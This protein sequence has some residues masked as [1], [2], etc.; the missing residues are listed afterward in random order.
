M[1]GLSLICSCPSVTNLARAIFLRA[2]ERLSQ[3]IQFRCKLLQLRTRLSVFAVPLTLRVAESLSQT[4]VFLAK[5]IDLIFV[6]TAIAALGVGEALAKLA[7]FDPQRPELFSQSLQVRVR[8]WP[9]PSS[10]EADNCFVF[11]V[12]PELLRTS[13][14][15]L[16]TEGIL[17]KSSSE[18]GFRTAAGDP[19][20]LLAAMA[21]VVVVVV[22]LADV[23]VVEVVV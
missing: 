9:P 4:V 22:G 14:K 7:I 13:Q 17:A 16:L 23:V 11:L 12:A 15:A 8:S 19:A 10:I 3:G 20:V 21:V 5:L 2:A 6:V 18:G 1:L